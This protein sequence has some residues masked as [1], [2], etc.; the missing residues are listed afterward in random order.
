MAGYIM[1]GALLFSLWEGWNYIEGTYFCFVTL[2]T[3]GF[4]DFVPGIEWD[5]ETATDEIR[6]EM[7]VRLILCALYVF[8]GLALIGMC[9][10]LMQAD[11]TQKIRWIAQKI[12]IISSDDKR[13]TEKPQKKASKVKY[14]I[15]TAAGEIGQVDEDSAKRLGRS[16]SKYSEK[17]DSLNFEDEER[18]PAYEVHDV[19]DKGNQKKKK[20][21]KKKSVAE[22]NVQFEEVS[23][24]PSPAK[25]SSSGTDQEDAL[26]ASSPTEPPGK[27]KKDKKKAEKPKADKKGKKVK[28]KVNPEPSVEDNTPK[29]KSA[30]MDNLEQLAVQISQIG[31]SPS[32]SPQ[33]PA[34]HGATAATPSSYYDDLPNKEGTTPE[35]KRMLDVQTPPESPL[36]SNNNNSADEELLPNG[37]DNYHQPLLMSKS[38]TVFGSKHS[39]DQPVPGYG[40]LRRGKSESLTGSDL[41]D[42]ILEDPVFLHTN[43]NNQ[44]R[45]IKLYSDDFDDD[46]DRQLLTISRENN[47]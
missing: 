24:E 33:L 26:L 13:S 25:Q 15:A 8:F 19:L 9:I 30:Q 16:Q 44:N 42:R 45:R 27:G 22:A 35:H 34:K 37:I 39:E 28:V 46:D 36:N 2:T 32:S 7:M 31:T 4:G 18:P 3:I 47:V 20:K 6:K 12:G 43:M 29:Q 11:V 14:N 41:L 40:H 21:P 38:L 17:S 23:V 5:P 10:D 1:G